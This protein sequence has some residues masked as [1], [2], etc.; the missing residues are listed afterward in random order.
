MRAVGVREISEHVGIRDRHDQS[1][2][3]KGKRLTIKPY[4]RKSACEQPKYWKIIGRE[5]VGRH[6][7]DPRMDDKAL[8][9]R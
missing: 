5:K 3:A 4:E 8:P 1:V 6:G 7:T 2:P 9:A